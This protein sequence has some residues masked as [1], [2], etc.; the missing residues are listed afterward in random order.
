MLR[1]L[2]VQTSGESHGKGMAAQITGFPAGVAVDREGIDAELRRR[3]GGFG[4]S[5]RQKLEHD[6]VEILAGVYRGKTT[7]A[8]L[9]LMV[10]N[11]DDRL[12]SV[13]Q[14]VKPRPGHGDLA[15]GCKYDIGDMRPV[16]ERASARETAARVAAGALA[17]GLL[18]SL[19]V[20]VF[21]HVVALGPQ[22]AGL[23]RSWSDVAALRRRRDASPFFTLDRKAGAAMRAAVLAAREA[24]D[25]LGGM[26]EVRAFGVPPGLG[27]LEGFG[28]RLDARLA[29]AI[30]SIPAIKAV[31]L[32]D[33][34]AA[35]ALPGSAVHDAVG[36]PGAEGPTRASNRAGG[37]EAGMSNGQPV[38]LRAW[39]KPI[40]TLRKPLGTWDYASDRAASAHF[41]R[42]DVTAVPAASVVG[43]AMTALVLADALLEKTGGDTLSEIRAALRRHRRAVRRRFGRPGGGPIRPA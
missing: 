9:H 29:G 18:E 41:E 32:G 39:M 17:A 20:V 12:D 24:G 23:P 27:S 22:T 28:S 4:R 2:G 37:I 19:G 35:A 7:G 15:G 31:E 11:R 43:E 25:T 36:R 6:Q 10:W 26:F 34:L 21:G 30:M 8:P 40:P 38:V 42:S 13:E 1:R 14:V 16:L 33:G 3:Q 5:S